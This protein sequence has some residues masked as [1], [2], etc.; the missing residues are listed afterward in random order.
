MA[1]TNS[2]FGSMALLAINYFLKDE[3]PKAPVYLYSINNS[4]T[5]EITQGMTEEEITNLETRQELIDIN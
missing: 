3:A 2:G 5:F 1:D 4:N